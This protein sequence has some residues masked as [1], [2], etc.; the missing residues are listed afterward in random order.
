M[1]TV[2]ALQTQRALSKSE[3]QEIIDDLDEDVVL[4][5]DS[6]GNL[7][8]YDDCDEFLGTIDFSL[9]EFVKEI[10]D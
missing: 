3:L 6:G 9:K 8:V 5:V 1:Q 10:A 2:P 7:A 4:I